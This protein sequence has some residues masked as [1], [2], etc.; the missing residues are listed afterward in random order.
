MLIMSGRV[1]KSRQPSKKTEERHRL[2]ALIDSFGVEV[3]PCSFCDTRHLR[4]Q[5]ME[6][7]SRCKECVRRGRSC[8]GVFVASSI[9]KVLAAEERLKLEEEQTEEKLLAAQQALN[10]AVARLLR[11]RK[12]RASL[13]TRG[14][15]LAKRCASSLDELDAQ[16]Q[17][18]AEATIDAQAGG[19][20][21]VID[22]SAV[23]G[24][25]PVS[26]GWPPAESPSAPAANSAGAA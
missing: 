6:G 1:E 7:V 14:V 5:M 13:K 26:F 22:W 15:D 3:M 10:E 9:Q 21:D 23:F 2:I 12:Q 19:A 16:E 17:T 11:I 4:C 8:D 24:A 18:E 25:D 20:M